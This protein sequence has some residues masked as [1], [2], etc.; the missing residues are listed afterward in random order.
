MDAAPF[1]AVMIT[2]AIDHIPPPLLQQLTDGGRLILPLGSPFR[3]QN[4]TL[5]TK[6]NDNCT[7]RQIT[8]VLVGPMTGYAMDRPQAGA[9]DTAR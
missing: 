1:D 5:V 2:A 8:G 4:L 3:Y 7:V 9:D 6:M